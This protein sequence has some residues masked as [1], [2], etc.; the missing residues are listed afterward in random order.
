[1]DTIKYIRDLNSKDQHNIRA[2]VRLRRD[3][4]RFLV[5]PDDAAASVAKGGGEY[6]LIEEYAKG[7]APP[8]G[9]APVDPSDPRTDLIEACGLDLGVSPLA[10][11]EALGTLVGTVDDKLRSPEA[12]A[13]LLESTGKE[14]L[15]LKQWRKH[16]A[17]IVM[18]TLE[19]VRWE[20]GPKPDPDGNFY[21]RL[22]R[23]L[24][25]R[26]RESID[27][28][29]GYLFLLMRG[30][31]TL[32]SYQGVLWRGVDAKGR[33]RCLQE[34]TVGRKVHWSAF[35]S[36]T[37][38]REVAEMF[39]GPRGVL[40]RITLPKERRSKAR[41]IHKL[42]VFDE[43]EVLLLPNFSFVVSDT[44]KLENGYDVIDLLE[45]SRES[46]LVF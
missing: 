9:E 20:P 22:N 24:R 17:A 13:L 33:E 7:E 38:D 28:I 6:R 4:R 15:D 46:T 18:F 27:R 16:L 8:K 25:E 39:A 10:M 32:P 12:K 5:A 34:Y 35:S 14:I 3:R 23:R 26:D 1:M 44:G 45:E 37:P 19:T 21:S 31:L 42:S 11:S 43:R 30:L 2:E 29:E 41:D 36:T 40:L